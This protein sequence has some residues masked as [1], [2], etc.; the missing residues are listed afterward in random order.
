MWQ[1]DFTTDFPRLLLVPVVSHCFT[2][3]RNH[4]ATELFY[5][6]QCS[7]TPVHVLVLV[8]SAASLSADRLIFFAEIFGLMPLLHFFP[9]TVLGSGCQSDLRPDSLPTSFKLRSLYALQAMP[10]ILPPASDVKH[11]LL[12]LNT[13]SLVRLLFQSLSII[14]QIFLSKNYR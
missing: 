8:G 4:D 10:S 1:W 11:S 12:A 13:A 14:S 7:N 2:K 3:C 5:I 9:I 6:C